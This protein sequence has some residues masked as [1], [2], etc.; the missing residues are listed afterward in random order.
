M[1]KL[2][3]VKLVLQ[4]PRKS[5]HLNKREF[6][7]G[8]DFGDDLA[9]CV[10]CIGIPLYNIGDHQVI[11][12][13]QFND[14]LHAKKNLLP[15]DEWYKIEGYRAL[16]QALGRCLR[17]RNDWGVV[18]IVDKR[19][20]ETIKD[21]SHDKGKIFKWVIDNIKLYGYYET[22]RKQMKTFVNERNIISSN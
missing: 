14:K 19:L 12:K 22:F 21:N 3:N 2:K 15:D 17:H 4:E 16:N 20:Y 1:A 10:I 11:E 6:S 13:R 18:I 8:I 9:R 7:E 5:G